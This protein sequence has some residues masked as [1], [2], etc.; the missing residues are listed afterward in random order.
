MESFLDLINKLLEYVELVGEIDELMHDV[1]G[2]RYPLVL[3][4]GT[5]R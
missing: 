1:I 4:D 3:P 2:G 5:V